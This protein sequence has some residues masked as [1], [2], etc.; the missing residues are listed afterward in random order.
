MSRPMRR[1]ISNITFC[2]LVVV[3]VTVS[4]IFCYAGVADTAS[5][6]IIK[7]QSAP[8]DGSG[9]CT[10][11]V[12][13]RSD[14][15]IL[16]PGKDVTLYT[17][18]G[19]SDSL[20]TNPQTTDANGEC[21]FSISSS[22]AGDDTVTAVCE[23]VTIR[24]GIPSNFVIGYL[25]EEDTG[26]TVTVDVSQY[27][28]SGTLVGGCVWT[29]GRTGNGLQLNGTNGEIYVQNYSSLNPLGKPWT[30]AAWVNTNDNDG[31]VLA[32]GGSTHGYS[33]YI[34]GGMATFA[35][36]INGTL[37]TVSSG[38][39]IRG[40]WA[41][42]AG[43]IDSSRIKIYV[44]GEMK[45][46]TPT[47]GYLV[48]N[49]SENMQVGADTS[50]AVGNYTA[51]NW[52]SATIDDVMIFD[53]VLSTTEIASLYEL[54]TRLDFTAT[55]LLF[56]TP[57]RSVKM[58]VDSDS[59]VVIAGGNSGVTADVSLS[60]T[61]LLASSSSTG[62][63]SISSTFWSDTTLI[64][65][66][67]GT[68]IF[69]YRDTTPGSPTI[70]VSRAGLQPDTQSINVT[71]VNVAETTSYFRILSAVVPAD[72]TAPC[73]VV[74]TIKEIDGNPIAG[75][76]VTIVTSRGSA[77]DTIT[78]PSLTDSNGQCTAT[79][80]SSSAGGDTIYALC[81]GNTIAENIIPNPSFEEGSGTD[82][83]YWTEGSLQT[84]S[85]EQAHSGSY[86]LRAVTNATGSNPGYLTITPNSKYE[87]SAW[88][89][90]SV[91][92]GKGYCDLSD[93][94]GDPQLEV[95][96]SDSQGWNY[97]AKVWSNTS[98][99]SVRPRT[100]LPAGEG[101]AGTIWFD[102]IRL[103][104]VPTINWSGIQ[105]VITSPQRA[106]KAGSASDSITVEVQDISGIL[107][108]AY[109]GTMSITSS[110]S[111]GRFSSDATTWSS[112]NDTYTSIV[113]GQAVFYYKDSYTGTYTITVSRTGL[114]QDT[115]EI[116]V[117][118][119]SASKDFS[120]IKVLS[121]DKPA[122]GIT[123][124]T[125]VVVACD[126]SGNPVPGKQISVSTSRGNSD[127]ISPAGAQITDENGACTFSIVSGYLGEATVSAY[128]GGAQIQR[129]INYTTGLAGAWRLDENSGSTASDISGYNSNGT[130]Y[131]TPVRATG[132]YGSCVQLDG[133][134]DYVK[135]GNATNLNIYRTD[136]TVEARVKPSSSGVVVAKG[137]QSY[138]YA[139]YVESVAKFV[140]TNANTRYV[141]TGTT[142]ITDT[143]TH[144]VG[145]L[146][147]PNAE[148]YFNGVR[149]G[150][151]A[152]NYINSEP[153]EDMQFGLDSSTHVGDYTADTL[154]GLIDE[155]RVYSKALSE[156]EIYNA[157]QG[158]ARVKFTGSR[159]KI[160]STPKRVKAGSSTTGITVKVC[161][162]YTNTDTSSGGTITLS[163]SSN[164]GSF[165]SNGQNWSAMGIETYTALINGQ[166]NFYYRDYRTGNPVI[167]VSKTGLYPDT[168]TQ[169]IAASQFS[170][171]SQSLSIP[172]NSVSETMTIVAT[173][174]Y[175][176]TDTNFNSTVTLST[177][178][179]KGKFSVSATPWSDTTNISL[180]SG[181][182]SFHYRDFRGGLV[183]ITVADSGLGISAYQS[184]TVTQPIINIEKYQ[185]NLRLN[186]SGDSTT[187]AVNISS[188]DT[189]EYW[190]KVINTGTETATEIVIT[191][192]TAFNTTVYTAVAFLEMDTQ[193]YTST[194]WYTQDPACLVWVQGT[195]P[196]PASEGIKGLKFKIDSLAPAQQKQIKFYIRIN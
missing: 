164:S 168:Q 4:T 87:Y 139:L 44:N 131:G 183:T 17:S 77:Y 142:P 58:G 72:G 113:N 54:R 149:Q 147:Y 59:I 134:D 42:V 111:T 27:S 104:R 83:Y 148:I 29:S 19:D 132:Y 135:V 177:S 88:L 193:G 21:T 96:T 40:N 130:I 152:A 167:T 75:K 38:V 7:T 76:Q 78:Q 116:I 92:A 86:S 93:V 114:Q 153:S 82:A 162:N 181:I 97:K 57:P 196:P 10:V 165:S 39:D 3:A 55:K 137:G 176:N 118:E 180:G 101:G 33:L 192:T 121:T 112:T 35:I 89:Y 110:S 63:F 190:L 195:P 154:A 140:V 129:G 62:R 2:V 71:P 46:E 53:R 188:G 160:S 47:A 141:A 189:I 80:L 28:N 186:P 41:H 49:P 119:A 37:Y 159:L 120:Y 68:G 125:V 9:L 170:F 51:P 169:T 23:G 45:G 61:V 60:D 11:T 172:V 138:G 171:I 30:F 94:T 187:S 13:V 16:L 163:T 32:R 64:T 150:I 90:N 107:D 15:G 156:T 117:E 124:C 145:V 102:D 115:Q 36:R 73:T 173:D 95:T 91:T 127:T 56:T 109:S 74:V 184:N 158:K 25:F 24:K 106:A 22:Y 98:Y 18:R 151:I 31:V 52:L 143:W 66:S 84:R 99:T 5:F 144:L 179:S 1:I 8:A 85:S 155:V 146:R 194:T 70:S 174:Q 67:K 133:I 191:D 100:A 50:T 123:G 136:L 26:L 182:G 14:T 103:R 20:S 108:S 178:S 175:G 81:D 34:A 65:L 105:L 6:I 166:A 185:R 161:D 43:V 79:I 126:T 128:M 12:K 122:D 48:S 69:Y 157:Y